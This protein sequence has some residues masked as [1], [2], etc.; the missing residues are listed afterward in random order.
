MFSRNLAVMLEAGLSLN[1]SLDV[2]SRQTQSKKLQ[3]TIKNIATDIQK[4]ESFSESLKKYPKIFSPLFRS[5]AK[6]GEESGK[7]AESLKI[8][9][10]QLKRDHDLLRKIRGALIYP[11]IIFITMVAAG[12]LMLIYV[13]PTLV[14]TFRELEIELPFTTKIVIGLSELILKQGLLVLLAM[15][16]LASLSF[17]FLRIQSGKRFFNALFL[18]L[19]LVSSLVKK[20]N[21]AR[22]ART[23]GSLI[24]SGVD[25]VRA[26]EVTSDVLQ[27]YRYKEVL[28]RAKAKIQKG[29]PIS[30]VF[31]DAS[32]LYAPLVGEMMAVGEETGKLSQMLIRVAVFYENEVAIA[33]R[34]LST[35][36]EPFLMIVVGVIVGF[37]AVSMIS[38]IYSSLGNL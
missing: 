26:L 29:S 23:L 31:I 4:G 17:W 8:I 21:A 6:A 33:T 10:L 3:S 24:E 13:V 14:S 34:D 5:M 36:I 19:P 37:F 15:A 27:N 20:T 32:D 2:L 35:I 28:T 16:A 1:K 11:L 22:T 38:P 9:S 12:V 7:L 25:L 18:R 30:S